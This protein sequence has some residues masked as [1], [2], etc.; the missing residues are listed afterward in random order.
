MNKINYILISVIV[1]LLISNTYLYSNLNKQGL[2]IKKEQISQSKNIEN[3]Q[4]LLI[5]SWKKYQNND[6]GLSFRYPIY[7]EVCTERNFFEKTDLSLGIRL[8]ETC[9]DGEKYK[10]VA[11][12]YITVGQNSN[13]Y[14]TAEEAFYAE[15]LGINKNV[16]SDLKY[17]KIKDT[18]V[19][20]GGIVNKADWEEPKIP[21]Q[22]GLLI[23]KNNKILKIN[24]YNYQNI[25]L[26]TDTLISS[27]T[28]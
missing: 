2:D 25:K 3:L 4:N 14:K 21:D 16:N 20:G 12:M 13:N 28:F 7:A 5:L 18:D 23:L 19:Y 24:V 11:N 27:L 17:F 26:I 9:A 6:L 8:D 1:I 10:N 15:F 22:Y